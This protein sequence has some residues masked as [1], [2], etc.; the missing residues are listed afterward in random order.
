MRYS[1]LVVIVC[2]CMAGAYGNPPDSVR[3]EERKGNFFIIHQVDQGET[4]YSLARRYHTDPK[5]IIKINRI[6]NNSISIGQFLEIP[7]GEVKTTGK[8]HV[9]KAGETLFGVSKKYG[10][11]IDELKRWNNLRSNNLS[12][13]QSLV[14]GEVVPINKPR[15]DK[16]DPDPQ[17][18]ETVIPPAGKTM[19]PYYVQTGESLEM[20]AE[21]FVVSADSILIWNE[22]ENEELAIGQKL[23]FPFKP[24]KAIKPDVKAYGTEFKETSYGSKIKSS[25]EGGVS[26]LY[27]EGI[28]RKIEGAIDTD[29]Y[30]AL[31]RTLS[32]GT[33]FQVKNIMNNQTIYVRVVGQLPNTGLNENVMIR[34]TSIAFE[35]L[36]IVDDK[37][38]V[39]ISYFGD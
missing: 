15:A 28:A 14:I 36:G 24:E 37:A 22:L 3:M 27:E 17:P 38:L 31:H 16:K 1:L 33:V 6:S 35:R 25:R 32:V 20:I 10:V 5:D 7:V 9:V 11:T 18:A 39:A 12:V 2:A 8:T 21:K 4:I 29:K 23:L 19:Y 30:L 26:K 13:G 34:L